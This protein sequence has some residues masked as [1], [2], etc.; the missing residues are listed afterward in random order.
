MTWL[1]WARASVA[2]APLLITV[3]A[4]GGRA[5]SDIG[6]D[7][8]GQGRGG[9]LSIG[10][11]AGAGAGQSP[12]GTAGSCAN[13]TVTFKMIAPNGTLPGT[14]CDPCGASWLTVID[15][16]TS[17]PV[18]L[19][20]GCGATE[21][22]RCTPGL[23]LPLACLNL[24]VTSEGVTWQWDSS[25][26]LDG[27]CGANPTQCLKPICAQPGKYVARMCTTKSQPGASAYSCIPGDSTLCTEVAFALPGS[28]VV[29]GTIGG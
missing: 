13:G 17:K 10:G 8:S 27:T 1:S 4:C 7:A 20:H 18:V 25:E 6:G 12:G 16:Q 11:S 26:W 15:Q 29:T 5:F 21:C 28:T 3:G 22:S 19:D 9:S 14:Y 24:P 2:C 23:C